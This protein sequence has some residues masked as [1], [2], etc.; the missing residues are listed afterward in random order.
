[1]QDFGFWIS[2]FGFTTHPYAADFGF[3]ISDFDSLANVGEEDP[4][5]SCVIRIRP[6]ELVDETGIFEGVGCDEAEN[7]SAKPLMIYW[8]SWCLGGFNES[9]ARAR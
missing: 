1:M 4:R 9:R 5:I 8:W 7:C 3:W 6:A 2:D